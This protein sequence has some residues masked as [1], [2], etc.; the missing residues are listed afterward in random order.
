LER[1]MLPDMGT[2]VELRLRK[3]SHRDLL[4]DLAGAVRAKGLKMGI[5]YRI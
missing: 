3:V 2:P 4:G 5:Y 1:K